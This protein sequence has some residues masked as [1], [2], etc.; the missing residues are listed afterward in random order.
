MGVSNAMVVEPVRRVGWL[1]FD[2]LASA[3]AP[4]QPTANTPQQSAA[5]TVHQVPERCW[6][7]RPWA[8]LGVWLCGIID[9]SRRG[10]S[11]VLGCLFDETIPMGTV[12]HEALQLGDALGQRRTEFTPGAF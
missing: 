11:S 8:A 12:T 7:G 2:P 3:W 9:E 4:V 6:W 1:T 5:P 10:M